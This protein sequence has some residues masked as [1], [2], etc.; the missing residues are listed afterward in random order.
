MIK[1]IAHAA[2]TVVNMDKSLDYYCN[3]LGFDHSFSI[4]NDEDKPWIEYLQVCRGQFIEL[5]YNGSD[6]NIS[7]SYS[8]LCL[9]VD[10]IDE[11]AARIEASDYELTRGVG[12]GKDGNKQ[13]WSKDPDGNRIEFMQYSPDSLQSKAGV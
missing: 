12:Q 13:C 10:D 5:F 9:E 1:G 8:H 7:N 3:V 4:L 2:Y 6:E 11:I